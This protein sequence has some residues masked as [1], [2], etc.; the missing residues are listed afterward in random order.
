MIRTTR[1]RRG[2]TLVEMLVAAALSIT[3][4]WLLTWVYQ[5]GVD[6]LRLGNATAN[7]T[8]QEKMVTSQMTRDLKADHF[9]EE[10]NKPNRG[11]RLSDQTK[12]LVDG[13]V[14]TK[15]RSGYFWTCSS[16]PTG[17]GYYSEGSDSYGFGSS[18]SS[19]HFM[20]FTVILSGGRSDQ[21]FAAEVPAGGGSANQ[22]FGT[23]AEVSYYLKPS[24]TS[25]N[26]TIPVFD[27]YRAQKL[28]AR[29]ADDAPS[30]APWVDAVTR[31]DAPEVMSVDTTVTP[32]RMRALAELGFAPFRVQPFTPLPA[33]SARFGEDKLMSGVLLLEI[34]YTGSDGTPAGSLTPPKWPVSFDQ[35]NTDFPYDFLPSASG[36][37]DTHGQPAPAPNATLLKIRITG[38]MIRVRAY[39][40]QTRT[41]RQTTFTVD[42]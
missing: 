22:V 33:T 8:S 11:R 23:A 15:P 1:T 17:T 27:L 42:L 2:V 35:G 19:N 34:K 4:M 38:A 36:V 31:P 10:D 26:G 6:S 16:G 24:G 13:T 39:D 18:R 32:R 9:L 30:Y 3:G 37:F 28:V 41:T 12:S 14:Y 20:Q 21:T 29:T 25:A 7:L 40:S 5:Q